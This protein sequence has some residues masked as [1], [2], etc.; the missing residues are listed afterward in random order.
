MN[1]KKKRVLS[2]LIVIIVLAAISCGIVYATSIGNEAKEV[3]TKIANV[4]HNSEKDG[5]GDVVIATVNGYEVTKNEFDMDK[6]LQTTTT[7]TVKKSY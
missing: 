6:P 1:V 3:G 4:I 5:S 7:I 2:T